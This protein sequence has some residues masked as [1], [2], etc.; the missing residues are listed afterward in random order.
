M[1]SRQLCTLV[2]RAIGLWISLT[3]LATV[4]WDIVAIVQHYSFGDQ[5]GREIGVAAIASY[6][7]HILV[8]IAGAW[9]LIDGKE[10]IDHFQYV[11]GRCARCG[12]NLMKVHGAKCPEC[13]LEI[14]GRSRPDQD[15]P[16]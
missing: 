7:A 15:S 3:Y 1:N 10:L 5:I 13:G 8:F 14:P 12:Y 11:T 6:A 2:V 9:M 16:P 4:V